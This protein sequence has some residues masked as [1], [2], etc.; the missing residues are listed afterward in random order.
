MSEVIFTDANFEME[1]LKSDQPVLV[2][3]FA[4]WCGPCKMQGPIVE[5][6]AKELAG[7][8][9]VGKL[10]VDANPLMAEKFEVMSI[11]TLIVFKGG[12]PAEVMTGLQ[13]KENLISKLQ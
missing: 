10:D 3:F 6:V 1:V 8:V 5:A 13:S 11:P 4:N 12:Q 9:K 2:D 7:R